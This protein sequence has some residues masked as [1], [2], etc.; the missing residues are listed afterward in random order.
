MSYAVNAAETPAELYL[1]LL[2][3]MSVVAVIF[4]INVKASTAVKQMIIWIVIVLTT[5][6]I[7][8]FR[9]NLYQIRDRVYSELFPGKVS[10]INEKQIAI[11]TSNDGHFY[12]DL[13]VNTWPVH[14]MIDTGASDIILNS[15]DSKRVGIDATNMVSFRKYQT[16]N[17]LIVSGLASVRQIEVSSS[18]NFRNVIVAVNDGDM[19]TSLLGMSFLSRFESY[20]VRRGRL[21]L[22]AK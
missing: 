6:A 3:T 13:K 16:A 17:G 18:I 10:Q 5:L 12:I 21:V 11:V 7:Y 19:G 4:K 14:F 8:S 20:E 9:D 22:T 15:S 2:L 1:L